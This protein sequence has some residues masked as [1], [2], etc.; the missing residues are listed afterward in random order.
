MES[1]FFILTQHREEIQRLRTDIARI[2]RRLQ[3]PNYNVSLRREIMDVDAKVRLLLEHAQT[4][5]PHM[6]SVSVPSFN[7]KDYTR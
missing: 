4:K 6:Q 5:V 3:T 2:R 1:S 7:T